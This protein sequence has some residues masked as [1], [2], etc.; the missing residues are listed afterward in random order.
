MASQIAGAR[1]VELLGRDHFPW[2]GDIEPIIG[3]IRQFVTGERGPAVVTDRVLATVMFTD[4]VGS[5][6][7]AAALGDAAWRSLL[8]QYQT[9]VSREIAHFRG[10]EV[11]SMGDGT[12]ATFDGP[13]RAI[14]CATAIRRVA[15]ELGLRVRCGLHCGEV[16][17]MGQDVGGIAV[18]LA[19]RVGSAA[20]P[21]EVLVTSTVKDLVAGSGIEFEDR[22][23][24]VLKD[25]PEPWRCFVVH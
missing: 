17:V 5:T 4:I 16:E 6:E 20:Q 7:R 24:P 10:V 9:A 2:V 12:L 15:H 1:Y 21:D 3:E 11:K 22:G 13:G 25:I 14:Q 8:E 18:H 23:T 19:A